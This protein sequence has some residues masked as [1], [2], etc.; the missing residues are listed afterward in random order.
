[1]LIVA[2]SAQVV[3]PL[4]FTPVPI[5]GSTFGVLL[6]AAA[7][8]PRRGVISLALY[9]VLGVVGLPIFQATNSGPGYA[10]GS[11]GGYLIGFVVAAWVVGALARRG[12]DRRP[13]G[14]A[15]AFIVG[16]LVIYAFGVPWLAF[17]LKVSLPEAVSLGMLPFLLGDAV[18]AVLAAGL[19]PLA[20]K[21]AG[22]DQPAA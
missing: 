10:L 4:P 13:G 2:A 14:T 1:M 7:L 8:G 17:V 20:W 5:T 12:L 16:S 11:T 6:A 15:V 3:I 21:L 19:L 22:N 18:K 9:L